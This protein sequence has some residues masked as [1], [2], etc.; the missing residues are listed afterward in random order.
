M[1]IDFSKAFDSFKKKPGHT[2]QSVTVPYHPLLP[3]WYFLQLF[4]QNALGLNKVSGTDSENGIGY[5]K[6]MLLNQKIT[7]HPS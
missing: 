5:D 3:N 7:G 1:A 2:L 4:S 6:T